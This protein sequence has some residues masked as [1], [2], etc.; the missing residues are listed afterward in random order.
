M[1]PGVE[2]IFDEAHEAKG[3]V[4][5]RF[6]RIGIGA[7]DAHCDLFNDLTL[8]SEE[9][10]FGDANLDS[11]QDQTMAHWKNYHGESV[12]YKCVYDQ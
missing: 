10:F 11:S 4:S 8:R 12:S 1:L 5:T 2:A 7:E 3:L 9:I 6:D